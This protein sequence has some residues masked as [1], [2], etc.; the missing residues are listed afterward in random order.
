[1]NKITYFAD[2][3]EEN[4]Q[5]EINKLITFSDIEQIA[6]FPDVHFASD[7]S[8]PVG[9]SFSS[10]TRFYPTVTGKDMGCGVAYMRIP[11]SNVIAEFNNA[12]HYNALNKESLR[13]TDEGLGGGNH[14]LSIEKSDKALYIIV[15]TGS[16]NRGIAQFQKNRELLQEIGDGISL[17]IEVA[18]PE[19]IKEYNDILTY[20]TARRFEFLTKTKKFLVRNKYVKEGEYFCDDSC[21]NFLEFNTPFGVIHRKGST[22]LPAG[23]NVVIPISM[24]RGSLIV[25]PNI[26]HEGYETSVQSCSHGAGRKLTRS[27]TSKFWYN[28]PKSKKVLMKEQYYY[29]L[30]KNGEFAS[31]IIQEMDFAYKASDDIMKLQPYINLV[32]Q[33]VPVTTIKFNI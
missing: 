28:L 27:D 12:V 26:Y 6:V 30:E 24:T 2:S 8:I 11:I 4:S 5:I 22:E 32:D 33:T 13:M 7:E 21:H 9:V 20:S 25:T 19:Y 31:S 18:T 23:K 3:I 17:P 10:R 1:M 14:F 15:H 16:R 29:L